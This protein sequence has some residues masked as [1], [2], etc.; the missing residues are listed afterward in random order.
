MS[1]GPVLVKINDERAVVRPNAKLIV[2]SLGPPICLPMLTN[3][4]RADWNFGE[5]SLKR[6]THK[7]P[8]TKHNKHTREKSDSLSCKLG[9]I[10]RKA[11][12]H[13]IN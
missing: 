7:I 6:K 11:E 12:K 9:Q 1:I 4:Q 13:Q 2:G 8:P 3:K 10:K 5:K